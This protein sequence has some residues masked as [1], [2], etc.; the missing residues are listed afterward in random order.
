M[1]RRTKTKTKPPHI[2]AAYELGK[3]DAASGFTKDHIEVRFGT[4]H[5]PNDHFGIQALGQALGMLGKRSA[6]LAGW[7][8]GGGDIL[9]GIVVTKRQRLEEERARLVT[10]LAE[11]DATLA[12][13]DAA[14]EQVRPSNERKEEP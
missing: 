10:R 14:R 4:K 9:R 8:A 1:R 6:W 12:N 5:D 3:Q 11:I 13:D 2:Q 7:E